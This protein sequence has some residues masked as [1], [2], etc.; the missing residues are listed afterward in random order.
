MR[1]RS[2][3]FAAAVGLSSA[4]L[5]APVFAADSEGAIPPIAGVR[6]LHVADGS[7]II[8]NLTLLDHPLL[9]G[10]PAAIALVTQ[11][12]NPRGEGETFNDHAVG[13]FYAI[14]PPRWAIYNEDQS[15]MPSGA[16]FNVLIHPAG[17]TAT[18]HTSA[19]GNVFDNYTDLDPGFS[20]DDATAQ[21][22]VTHN[23]N[24]GAVGGEL[25]DRNL[26]VWKNGALWSIFDEGSEQMFF[27]VDFNVA[28]GPVGGRSFLHTATVDNTLG[29][30]TYLDHP[31]SNGNPDAWV[32]IT[33]N[34]SPPA[35]ALV[36]GA[37]VPAPEGDGT[38]VDAALGVW[39]NGI[40]E[41]WAI[42]DEAGKF[43]TIPVGAAFNVL[44]DP[45]PSIFLD[46]F[47]SGTY[48][49]WSSVGGEPG[50]L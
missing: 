47:E 1:D 12:W 27:D 32:L 7:N 48:C 6:Y 17:S 29:N 20:Q 18:V 38:Y 5:A 42:F 30:L 3:T 41:K 35:P 25:H 8:S 11:V 36:E 23:Y 22:F 28:I 43:A 10:N 21:V 50:C 24:P 15:A 46:G 9:N 2:C 37:R 4:L 14:F 34:W 44:V 26:G 40:A 13:V 49:N 39:Y 16:G 31:D 45:S 33:H 19:E